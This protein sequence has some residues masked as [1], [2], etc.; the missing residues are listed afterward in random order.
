MEDSEKLR[1]LCEASTQLDHAGGGKGGDQTQV[2]VIRMVCFVIALIS[3]VCLL[4]VIYTIIMNPKLQQHPSSL[5]GSI[6]VFEGILV[7]LSFIECVQI[8]P[9]YI[10]CYT[11]AHELLSWTIR[12]FFHDSFDSVRAFRWI[13]YFN[14]VLIDCC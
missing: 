6:C 11:K 9:I 14:Q 3:L 12:P 13:I 5:I 1:K 8:G 7:W 2:F 10:N 4:S